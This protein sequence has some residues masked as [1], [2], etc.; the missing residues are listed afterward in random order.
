MPSRN[1]YVNVGLPVHPPGLHVTVWPT[2][3]TAVGCSSSD[4]VVARG[5]IGGLSLPW[6][7]RRIAGAET[8]AYE[9]PVLPR[10]AAARVTPIRT[11][12][13]P[14]RTRALPLSPLHGELEPENAHSTTPFAVSSDGRRHSPWS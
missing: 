8:S 4:T 3:M 2:C 5:A 14:G 7:N 6:M 1:S 12:G 9:E 13:G 11:G 10:H